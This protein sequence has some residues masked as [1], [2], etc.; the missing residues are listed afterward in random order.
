MPDHEEHLQ[1]WMLTV[2][3]R[4]H[5]R[6]IYQGG[7]YRRALK[8]VKQLRIA[9]DIGAHIGLWTYQMIHD[10][11]CVEAFEPMPEHRECWNENIKFNARM[12]PF[13][14]GADEKFVSV[15]TRT[16]DS[17]G[18]TGVDPDGNGTVVQQR[19]LDSFNFNNV[20]FIKIDCEGY[21]LFVCQGA[22]ETLIRCKPV[23]IV[24]QK[25]ETGGAALYNIGVTDAVIYLEELGY[26]K[27]E[28]IQGDYIMVW[29][30]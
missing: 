25:P 22:R 28:A 7:K 26:T 11:N 4:Q 2:Q 16:K 15:K 19:T 9:I 29:G 18:D 14:L 24:E 6:L 3:D 1:G 12:N 17:S 23:I 8:H 5:G 13:A 30:K 10:F 27:K 20:D 21:E